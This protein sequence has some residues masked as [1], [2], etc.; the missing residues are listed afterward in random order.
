MTFEERM[1]PALVN[2]TRDALDRGLYA[3]VEEFANFLKA[4]DSGRWRQLP[5]DEQHFWLKRLAD[6]LSG[7]DSLVDFMGYDHPALNECVA[8]VAAEEKALARIL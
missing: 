8:V 7:R 3:Y 4:L 1:K 2:L 5:V 6:R